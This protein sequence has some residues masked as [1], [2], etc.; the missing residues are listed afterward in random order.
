MAVIDEPGLRI[1]LD[2]E[3]AEGVKADELRATWARLEITV[4]DDVITQVDDSAS[5][6]I[7][8]AI[9]VPLFPF[10]EW[11]AFNWW[12]LRADTRPGYLPP[13]QWSFRSRAHAPHSQAHWLV[14]HNLRAIGDGFAWPDL[15]IIPSPGVTKLAWR[16]DRRNPPGWRVR[17]LGS[18]EADVESTSVQRALA[19]L[20]DA[21]LVRLD[22]Q[23]I[24]GTTL[25]D[26]WAAL[27][28]MDADE[29]EFCEAAARLGLDPFA[30]PD[31]V[32]ELITSAAGELEAPLFADF[33]DAADP[34]RLE[35][36]LRWI[37]E[38]SAVIDGAA[39]ER[40]PL[41]VFADVIDAVG[42]PWERGLRDARALRQR[43]GLK[44]NDRAEPGTWVVTEHVPRADRALLALGGRSHNASPVLALASSRSPEADRFA[45]ARALWRFGQTSST[46]D[47]FLLTSA[48]T[49]TQQS[50]RAFA[51]EFLAP[52][53]G[54][55][56]LLDTGDLSPV[57]LDEVSAISQHY[58]V[59]DWVIEYQIVNQLERPVDDR[60]LGHSE[61]Q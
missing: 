15:T 34:T 27:R 38:T 33:L 48:R 43:L 18:G 32:S 26:E 4:G 47:R 11:V 51:A 60:F 55:R 24:S 14:H 9:Y 22:E 54:I 61:L 36:D 12:F 13:S 41:P 58:G 35:G 7:R 50:E 52:A 42:L 20:V 31:S 53:D 19:A 5:G 8:R 28:S 2:W 49:R 44:T 21:V 37:A 40:E 10:A 56:T 29:V 46:T 17:Y 6:S 30:L 23:H 16:G 45:E 3:S 59:N 57:E 25:H 1:A 39:P